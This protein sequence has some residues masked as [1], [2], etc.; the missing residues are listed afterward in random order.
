M[1]GYVN[2]DVLVETGWVAEHAT[3]PGVRVVEANEDVSL[4]HA[5]HVP[6]AVNVDW[7]VDLSDRRVRDYVDAH[8][9]AKLMDRLGITRDTAVVFYGDQ[10]NWWAAHAYWVFRLLGHE[11]LRLMNGGRKKWLAEKRPM[12]REVPEVS[13]T[14]Y[15]IGLPQPGVRAFRPDVLHH[16]GNP[17]PRQLVVRLP[18]AH[19]LVDV[20]TPAEFSGRLFHMASYPQEGVVRGGHIPGAVNVPWGRA[21]AN[22]GT[23]KPGDEIR[24]LY[25][26]EGIT[27]DKDI[28]VYCRIGE[29]SAFTWFVLHELLGY[30][31]VRNY[32][33]SWTEW[34]NSVGVPIANPSLVDMAVAEPRSEGALSRSVA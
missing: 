33:G 15:A 32:D 7:R 28:I 5:G 9:F 16:I 14:S 6:G 26:G 10:A 23:F 20:R 19:A 22:D 25:E 13:P 34:G 24:R 18:A 4:Y 8:R 2:P 17:N 21:V 1:T 3:D 27:P 12:T 11:K 30:R 29:R 31:R